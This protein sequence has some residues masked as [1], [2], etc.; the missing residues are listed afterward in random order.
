MLDERFRRVPA[1]E[2]PTNLGGHEFANAWPENSAWDLVALGQGHDVDFWTRF[3]QALRAVDPEMTINIEHEDTSS[4]P[5]EGPR[6]AADVLT[7]AAG[8]NV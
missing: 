8:T 6:V 5:L 7:A 4:G 2:N 1:E 3:V